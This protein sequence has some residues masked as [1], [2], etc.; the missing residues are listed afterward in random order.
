PRMKLNLK[1]SLL[2]LQQEGKLFTTLF[3]HG[4][5]Q[6]EIYRPQKIDLQQPHSRDELY[7]IATGVSHFTAGEKEHE[8]VPGDVL[9]VP[10][11]TKHRFSQ[12]SH[13]FSTWVFF[14]G[15]E[16]GE[17]PQQSTSPSA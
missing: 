7:V 9:F 4:T 15:P 2:R 8:V 3:S 10:A 17:K 6:V 5:L 13:D 14:Y 12:F 1:E 11:G 16:G